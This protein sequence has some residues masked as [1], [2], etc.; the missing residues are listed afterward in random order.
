MQAN[1]TSR[2]IGR[3]ISTGFG[4]DVYSRE[5]L[6]AELASSM[7]LN[8]MGIIPDDDKDFKNNAAYLQGWSKYLKDGKMEIVK[9]AAQAQKA[10]NYFIET[11]E[12]QLEKEN[13]IISHARKDMDDA[14]IDR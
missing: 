4:T 6:I 14:S 3:K 10:V 13:A 9:A 2:G 1:Q 8:V 11:A 7:A 12:K 5:E